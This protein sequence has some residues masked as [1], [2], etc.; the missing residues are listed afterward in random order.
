MKLLM[1]LAFFGLV[2][3]ALYYKKAPAKTRPSPAQPPPR[4]DS[5]GAEVMSRCVHCGVYFPSS[6]AIHY[7]DLVYCSEEHRGKPASF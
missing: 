7:D 3:A 6:E 4:F 2:I 1:W 5:T